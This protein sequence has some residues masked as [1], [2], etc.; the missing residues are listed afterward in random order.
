MN[1]FSNEFNNFFHKI[2]PQLPKNLTNEQMQ[3]VAMYAMN[4]LMEEKKKKLGGGPK[5][6]IKF[7]PTDTRT[8]FSSDKK[9]KS[10]A[11]ATLLTYRMS[12]RGQK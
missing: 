5:E 7:N 8:P 6:Q 2:R 11:E 12:N 3:E 1:H 10:D 9:P 4:K